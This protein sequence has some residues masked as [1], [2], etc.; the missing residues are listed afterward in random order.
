M[1]HPWIGPKYDVTRLLLLGES[2]YSWWEDD[3]ERHPST[4]H[5]KESV[6]SSI[7]K[8]PQCGRFFA[9]LSRA[10]ANE[11]NPDSDRLRYVW[12]HVA[13][14]NYVSTTVGN[15]SRVRPTAKM[16]DDSSIPSFFVIQIWHMMSNIILYIDRVS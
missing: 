2:A 10:L 5:S 9:M 16:W 8:F 7:E 13:F 11:Q 1:F 12:N 4:E 3:E 14:T 6:Q 15:G